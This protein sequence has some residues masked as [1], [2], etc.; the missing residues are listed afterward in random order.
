MAATEEV[1][2]GSDDNYFPSDD[3]NAG[4]NSAVTPTSVAT[5]TPTSSTSAIRTSS[6]RSTRNKH[7]ATPVSPVRPP[8]N[9]R[10]ARK[11]VTP[12]AR[13]TFEHKTKDQYPTAEWRDVEYSEDPVQNLPYDI[14][15]VDAPLLDV[16]AAMVDRLKWKTPCELFSLF[17][18]TEVICHV[19]NHTKTYAMQKNDA[20]F[21]AAFCVSYFKRFMGIL[22]LSGMIKLPSIRD[23]WS[24]NPAFG[25][26]VVKQA[27]TRNMFEK[28]KRYLH[29]MN[30]DDIDVTDRF[31]K[32]RRLIDL[33]N[34][35]FM[36]FGVFDADIS[37]D[38]QMVPYVGRHGC[39]Q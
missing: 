7:V 20:N 13:F 26:V 34:V 36:R 24:T 22:I 2:V 15:R 16:R 3:D 38:E 21:A 37:I 29:F 23:Y 28:I 39:K 9:A 35:K 33:L 1:S 4:R 25:N 10:I 18:D 8:K 32:V 14:S 31:S 12:S 5:A 17:Y 6:R 11:D 19:V 27:M 30:N